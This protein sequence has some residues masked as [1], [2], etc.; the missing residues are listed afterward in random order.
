MPRV[1]I[2]A[3]VLRQIRQHARSSMSAEICG[4][5]IGS[6]KDGVTVVEASI[7][8][9]KARQGGS[10][11]TFT[12]QTWEHIYQVKD[13]TYP[14]KKIVGWYHS[15]PGFGVFLSDHDTF[16]HRNFFSDPN[17]IAWVY[18]P[19]SDEEGCFVWRQGEIARLPHL[20]IMDEQ[21][22]RAV[23][24]GGAKEE[25]SPGSPDAPG[26][27]QSVE[28]DKKRSSRMRPRLGRWTALLLTHVFAALLG[29]GIG[30]LLIPQVVIV[31]E[32]ALPAAGGK[33]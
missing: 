3:G 22:S 5:L 2:N 23:G 15:H 6:V 25:M 13:S 14:G 29:F 10:H 21:P 8:G 31:P 18:D 24:D 12:Q 28:V 26:Q 20:S 4:V 27:E 17:Q 33:K 11:V 19:H 9:Q 16:I 1:E 32:R 30:L 7:A